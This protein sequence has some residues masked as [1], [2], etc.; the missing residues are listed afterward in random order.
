MA[1]PYPVVSRKVKVSLY[2]VVLRKVKVLP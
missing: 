2:L 1:T